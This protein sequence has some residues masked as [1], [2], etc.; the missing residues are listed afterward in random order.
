MVD[1]EAFKRQLRMILIIY[2]PF[3]HVY[4]IFTGASH[5]E[6]CQACWTIDHFLLAEE[7]LPRGELHNFCSNVSEGTRSSH[8][9]DNE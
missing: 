7:R 2:I 4:N 5:G 9:H 1:L 8:R 6:K 3:F